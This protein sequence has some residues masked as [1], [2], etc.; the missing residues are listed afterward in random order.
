[1]AKRLSLENYEPPEKLHVTIAYIYFIEDH[2]KWEYI[3]KEAVSAIDWPVFKC[4]VDKFE[5]FKNIDDNQDAIVLLVK[6]PGINDYY[7]KLVLEIENRGLKVS[8]DHK[9]NPHITLAYIPSKGSLP[10]NLYDITTISFELPVVSIWMD[11]Q[12]FDFSY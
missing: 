8:K 11:D 6:I 7:N 4:Y 2:K 3:V 1:M 9:F 12:K 10:I 5:R